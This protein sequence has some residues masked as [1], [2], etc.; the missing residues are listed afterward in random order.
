M[1]HLKQTKIRLADKCSSWPN[2]ISVFLKDHGNVSAPRSS[3]WPPFI[4]KHPWLVHLSPSNP[5]WYKYKKAQ[6]DG[7]AGEHGG[8]VRAAAG[9]LARRED[10]QIQ[11]NPRTWPQLLDTYSGQGPVAESV[12]WFN[13][14]FSWDICKLTRILITLALCSCP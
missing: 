3:F 2:W 14:C 5:L 7:D 8:D 11:H 12:M 6:V 9:G 10:G 1:L 13:W 4:G